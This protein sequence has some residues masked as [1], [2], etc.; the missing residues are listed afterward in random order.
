[1]NKNREREKCEFVSCMRYYMQS[2]GGDMYKRQKNP[3][4][5]SPFCIFLQ[6][7]GI[8][9]IM[10]RFVTNAYYYMRKNCFIYKRGV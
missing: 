9:I 1:M 7:I 4:Q 6:V 10:P 5:Q 3:L 2:D 8:I